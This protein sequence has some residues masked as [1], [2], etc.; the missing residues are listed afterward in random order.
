MEKQYSV[1]MPLWYK[2][3]P[4]FL[5]A[6]IKSM[7]TQT[8][9]PAEF[10]LVQDHDI[11]SELAEAIKEGISD[12]PV[13]YID[14]YDLFGKGLGAILA[15]G[16]EQCSYDLIARMDS[17]DIS[18][19]DR[20]EKQLKIFQKNPK[21]A[22]VGGTVAEFSDTPQNIVSYRTVPKENSDIIKFARLR[23]PFNQPAVMFR[24]NIICRVGNYDVSFKACEDYE[25]W[26]RVLMNGGEGYNIVEPILYYR[27][28]EHLIKHRGER[29]NLE[30][31]IKLNKKMLDAK[32]S[33]LIDYLISVNVQRFFYYSPFFIQKFIYKLL[34]RKQTAVL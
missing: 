23:N 27:A 30:H 13:R 17:D 2:E 22:I 14:A 25:L 26:I 16:V 9:P 34:R 21:L 3:K 1:L 12:I 31:L 6:C 18:F 19:P 33:R 20:C 8:I 29:V 28:G 7:S 24:K 5:K 15:R 11:S 4:E 32:F 10:V